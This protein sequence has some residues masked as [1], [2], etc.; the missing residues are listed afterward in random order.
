MINKNAILRFE[1]INE[2]LTS[3]KGYTISELVDACNRRLSETPGCEGMTVKNR[4]V[5]YDMDDMRAIYGVE[6][7]ATKDEKDHRVTRF[8]YAEGTKNIH[9]DRLMDED[10]GDF[11]QAIW[12]LE[13]L[14]GLPYVRRAAETLKKRIGEG[15]RASQIFSV[16]SNEQLTGFDQLSIYF[17]YIRHGWAIRVTY[18]ARYNE[19]RKFLFQPYFLKQYNRRWFL[20]GW[21]Y[22]F[23]HR[24]G[25]TGIL[26]NLAIDRI[27]DKKVDMSRFSAGYRPRE[28]DIDFT[29]YFDDIIGVTRIPRSKVEHITMKVNDDYDW[30]RLVT[31]PMHTTQISDE[32]SRTITIDVRPN[33]ELYATLCQFEH[34][35]VVSPQAVREEHIA[36][37]R[38]ILSQHGE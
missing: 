15:G 16:E 21:N 9:G 25:T 36:R 14:V 26:Q 18:K 1:V 33:P 34:V 5:L 22:D 11:D 10:Y 4:Q 31:K 19:D 8:S 6:I 23:I 32:E 30:N 3:R 38:R 12:L 7:L 29:H 13:S 27:V 28:N 2:C 20:F 37:L 24:N 35:E 17:N